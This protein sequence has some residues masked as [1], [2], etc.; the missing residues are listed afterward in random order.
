MDNKIYSVYISIDAIDMLAGYLIFQMRGK[1]ETAAFRYAQTWLNSSQSFS[2]TPFWPLG[3]G[4]YY[5]N[6]DTKFSIFED[7]APDR[8][9][10]TLMQRY[11][12]EKA[13]QESRPAKTLTTVDYIMQ[14][15]DF[16]RQGALRFKETENGDFLTTNADNTVPPL[17][18]LPA[19]LHAA[20]A[21]MEN[22]DTNNDLALLLDPGSSLGGARPKATVIDDDGD[23]CIAKFPK[24]DDNTK[25]VTWEAV[26][27]DLAR[28]CKLNVPNFELKNIS[29]KNVLIIKRFDRRGKT[30]IPFASAMTMLNATEK[31]SRT[32]NYTEIA[33]F[34]T[35]YGVDPNKDLRELWMRVLFSVLISN[36][37]DHLR[38]HGFL[39]EGN[40]WRL[41]P[42]YDVNPSVDKVD[43][44]HTA[45]ADDNSDATIE[46]ALQYAEYF[47]ITR[48]EAEE[49]A[50]SMI[51]V[52]KNWQ[53]VARRYGLP[54]A[55]INRMA[56]AFKV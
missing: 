32:Y 44:L 8:W 6:E 50:N 3:P 40:G 41:S 51:N 49:I 37:D 23:L 27:L 15:N 43:M 38:N 4:M 26:A 48:A 13:Q 1:H 35:Q 14:V 52:L 54:Q 53:T 19:L 29:G 31:D 56:P 5:M 9:G 18:R 42:L 7:C 30:R 39:Y 46:N 11:E 22:A 16:A 21:V 33:D 28:Q 2:L 47:R 45:I 10:K 24:K 55:E 12:R 17:V 20:E 34:L 36:T 25:V